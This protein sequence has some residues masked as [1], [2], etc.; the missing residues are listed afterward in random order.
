MKNITIFNI[1]RYFKQDYAKKFNPCI[2]TRL[3]QTGDQMVNQRLKGRIMIV[4]F[5]RR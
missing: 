5:Q 4:F 3:V 2:H 1:L